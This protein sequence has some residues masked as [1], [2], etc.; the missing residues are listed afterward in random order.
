M[1][2]IP[3]RDADII[4]RQTARFPR[5]G[6]Q[7]N[8][9][10]VFYAFCANGKDFEPCERGFQ[11]INGKTH[12]HL[13][14][15]LGTDTVEYIK[16]SYDFLQLAIENGNL[17]GVDVV[18]REIQG[19]REKAFPELEKLDFAAAMHRGF[20]NTQGHVSPMAAPNLEED[21]REAQYPEI[22]TDGCNHITCPYRRQENYGL[23]CKQRWSPLKRSLDPNYQE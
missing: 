14:K 10:C 1:P 8:A 4:L 19:Y 15:V 7:C 16:N 21:R 12:E 5:K 18:T 13:E 9:S 20:T 11:L 2:T 23:P 22:C 6:D 17:E 3:K